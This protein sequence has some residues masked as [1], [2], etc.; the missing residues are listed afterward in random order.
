MSQPWIVRLL[1]EQE[2]AIARHQRYIAAHNTIMRVLRA[3]D[4]QA[5]TEVRAM[6]L[7]EEVV[8]SLDEPGLVAL[9]HQTIERLR[10]QRGDRR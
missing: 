2:E 10:E 8:A 6:A 9:Y 5:T 1:E 4:Q 3:L 7:L